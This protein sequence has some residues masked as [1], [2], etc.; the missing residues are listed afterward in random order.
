LNQEEVINMLEKIELK[1]FLDS[2]EFSKFEEMIQTEAFHHFLGLLLGSRQA[3]LMA[4]ANV[5]LGT[6][7]KSCQAS[8][9]QGTV[10]GIDLVRDTVVDLFTPGKDS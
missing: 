6:A 4:L 2:R 10:K 8:V 1:T 9:L 7:E 5:G 3:Q